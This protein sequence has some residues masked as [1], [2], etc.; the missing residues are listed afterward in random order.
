M[1]EPNPE[2]IVAF[3]S[4]EELG[5]WLRG[6]HADKQELWIKIY[7]KKSGVPSVGWNDVVIE[8]LCWGWIDGIKKSLDDE[9]YL[10][11]ITPR[12]PRSLW[13]K[14]N[15]EHVKRLLAEGQMREPGLVQVRAAQADGRWD[16]AYVVSEAQVPSDFLTAVEGHPEAKRNFEAFGKTNRLAIALGLSTAKRPETRQKRFDRF[17]DMLVRGEK[18]ELGFR[19]NRKEH[20]EK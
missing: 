5:D 19:E 9:V 18:P 6:H 2:R 1:P 7:K 10:Q 13:S 16:S 15:R 3:A 8:A 20:N 14:R 12:K 4:P 17:L 11:R